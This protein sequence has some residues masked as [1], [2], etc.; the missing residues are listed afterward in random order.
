MR[1]AFFLFF[2]FQKQQQIRNS[3]GV[4][5]STF[6]NT[7]FV[8]VTLTPSFLYRTPA[9]YPGWY[10]L[11]Y[12]SFLY[13]PFLKQYGHLLFLNHSNYVFL[14]TLRYFLRDNPLGFLSFSLLFCTPVGL[15]QL[16]VCSIEEMLA[17][18]S[19]LCGQDSLELRSVWP[20]SLRVVSSVLSSQ[21][22]DAAY[23]LPSNNNTCKNFFFGCYLCL[24]SE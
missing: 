8:Y 13:W 15:Y 18:R 20:A 22:K 5:E 3:R 2:Y 4:R 17:N 19:F 14:I 9:V 16:G 6:G 21:V 24:G 7:A 1:K 11:F 12:F 23:K 10:S